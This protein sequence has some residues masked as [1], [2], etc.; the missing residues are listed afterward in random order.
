MS[1]SRGTTRRDF[2]N[3]SALC[4]AAG[5][6]IAPLELMALS[7]GNEPYPPLATGMRGNHPGSFEVAHALAR[8]GQRWPDPT[9]TDE[10][11]YDLVIVGGGISGL[12][13]AHFYRERAGSDARILILD[14]HDDIGG[15][16][17]RNE[18][19]VDGRRLIG[20][21]GS[22]S[23]DTPGQYSSAAKRLLRDIGIDVERIY[24]WFDAGFD[25]RFGLLR[26]MHFHKAAYGS[27]VVVPDLAENWHAPPPQ[28]LDEVMAAVP[29]E[30][31]ERRAIR[32]LLAGGRDYLSHLGRD[33]KI[34]QLRRT[35]YSDFLRRHAG[36]PERVVR[37]YRDSIKAYWGIGWDALSSLE[38]WRLGAPGTAA[39]DVGA[40]EGEPQV[41]DEPCIFHFPDGNAGVVRG[42][43]RGLCPDVLPGTGIESLLTSRLAYERLDEPDTPCRI[44][45]HSTAVDVRHVGAQQAVAVSYVRDG[46]AYRV[47][48]AHAV[49]A[50]YNNMVPHLCPE[51]PRAQREALEWPEKAPIVFLSIALTNWRPFV[52]FGYGRFYVPESPLMD[53][54]GLDFPVS[55]G[56][57]R[58]SDDPDEPAVAAS[59]RAATSPRSP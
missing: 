30:D 52:E 31:H 51:I 16:A 55:I 26:G 58:F 17:K 43:L 56:S 9:D 27:D 2:L 23:I 6:G 22:Q 28:N 49:L 41:R 10:P 8:R 20:Y 11:D 18:F 5:S 13:A 12:A 42:L 45:L 47:R 40:L 46:R 29:L 44:R 36:M 38:A 34:V 15:H 32:E 57:Y 14:N 53:S 3:G 4:L 59:M 54:F 35:S 21:G 48:G 7:P 50:C 25:E 39:L 24:D 1:R 19:D 37:L 33:A